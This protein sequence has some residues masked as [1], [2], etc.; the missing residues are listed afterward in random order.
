MVGSDGVDEWMGAALSL[1][2]GGW[3]DGEMGKVGKVGGWVCR[4]GPVCPPW[5]GNEEWVIL[6]FGFWIRSVG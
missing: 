5:W 2:K 1:S 6:D 4:G 3:G